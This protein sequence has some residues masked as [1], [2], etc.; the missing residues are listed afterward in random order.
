MS[1]Q[2]A[3]VKTPYGS[4]TVAL[5]KDVEKDRPRI[6]AILG[7]VVLPTI[8]FTI[9]SWIRSMEL[10]YWSGADSLLL[11]LLILAV[12]CLGLLGQ[13]FRGSWQ[14]WLLSICVAGVSG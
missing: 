13:P 14:F 9:I 1:L 6:Y 7:R 11:C 10:H 8:L 4:I 3:S 5:K 2:D 12:T